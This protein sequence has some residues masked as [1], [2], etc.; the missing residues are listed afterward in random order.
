MSS[1]NASINY[2]P[3]PAYYTRVRVFFVL[4]AG[5]YLRF[6]TRRAE[7][8]RL[9]P[10]KRSGALSCTATS[11]RKTESKAMRSIRAIAPKND[12]RSRQPS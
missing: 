2:A 9:P 11:W 6:R 5:I 3:A 1:G 12:A 7:L 10:A 4:G 8:R